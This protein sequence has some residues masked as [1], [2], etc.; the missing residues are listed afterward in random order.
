MDPKLPRPRITLTALVVTIIL[1]VLAAY[2]L[3]LLK[4]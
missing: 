3:Y 2:L 1:G 4:I